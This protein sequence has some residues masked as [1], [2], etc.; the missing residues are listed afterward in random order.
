MLLS[1][2]IQA[3]NWTGQ[4]SPEGSTSDDALLPCLPAGCPPRC[5]CQVTAHSLQGPVPWGPWDL[6][7][8]QEFPSQKMYSLEKVSYRWF[9]KA[10][11][12]N[13]LGIRNKN[14]SFSFQGQGL[15]FTGNYKKTLTL[16]YE[17]LWDLGKMTYPS[18]LSILLPGKKKKIIYKVFLE[19]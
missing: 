2:S 11:S 4:H 3:R 17:L 15:V 5:V 9:G 7:H 16:N 8:P 1:S 13:E 6:A 14:G 18:W 12:E 19:I 10:M